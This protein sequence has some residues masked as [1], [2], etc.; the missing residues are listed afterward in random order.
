MGAFPGRKVVPYVLAQLA[1]SAAGVVLARIVWGRAVTLPSVAQAVIRPAVGWNPIPVFAAEAGAMAALIAL[2]GVFMV[3]RR[4]A[5]LVPFVIGGSVALVIVFQGPY[6]GGSINPAREFGPALL[7]G[8][9]TDLWIYLLAPAV[10]AALGAAVHRT[11][12]VRLSTARRVPPT[13][14]PAEASGRIADGQHPVRRCAFP[15]RSASSPC[16]APFGRGGR[17]VDGVRRRAVGVRPEHGERERGRGR[18]ARSDSP[19]PPAR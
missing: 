4:T 8:R 5:R 13:A 12:T 1:G 16:V 11:V 2:V 15:R 10:G 9:T 3:G 6:S 14:G 7:S 17:R 19:A 18:A